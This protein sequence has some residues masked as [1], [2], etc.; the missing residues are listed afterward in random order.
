MTKRSLK[1]GGRGLQGT[2]PLQAELAAM[3]VEAV[4][5]GDLVTDPKEVSL[6]AVMMVC[7]SYFDRNRTLAERLLPLFPVFYCVEVSSVSPTIV[8]T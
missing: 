2:T 6:C 3:D 1:A 5:A 7:H 4:G 8:T